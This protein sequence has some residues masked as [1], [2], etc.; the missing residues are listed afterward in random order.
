MNGQDCTV[1]SPEPRRNFRVSRP[2]RKFVWT[3]RD[4]HRPHKNS[5]ARWRGHFLPACVP[6][7]ADPCPPEVEAPVTVG[8]C[9]SC[10]VVALLYLYTFETAVALPSN[11]NFPWYQTYLV[12]EKKLEE[13]REINWRRSLRF[14]FSPIQGETHDDEW[15]WCGSRTAV[16]EETLTWNSFNE[17]LQLLLLI[18]FFFFKCT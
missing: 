18:A 16:E 7:T 15:T 12:G 4:V 5:I 8:W 14:S 9:L 6:N 10:A 1:G 11:S 13:K 17:S 2:R 3:L